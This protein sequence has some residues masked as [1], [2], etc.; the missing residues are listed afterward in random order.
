M[1]TLAVAAMVATSVVLQSSLVDKLAIWGI[2]PDLPL[3]L[4]I[5]LALLYGWRRGALVGLSAGL[6][7]DLLLGRYLG[8]DALALGLTG[9]LVGLAEPR[10][11]KENVLAVLFG[12]LSGTVFAYSVEFVILT[13]LGRP[14]DFLFAWKD[15]IAP[16]AIWNALLGPL[17]Y[18]QIYRVV[19][20]WQ[21]H[22]G[23][24][25]R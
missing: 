5:D 8:L 7:Q 21:Y 9:A 13:I 1:S 11:W 25:V 4:T 20:R 16:A 14:M 10:V 17:L 2:K 24:N 15:A 3:L 19:A 18:W 23:K 22:T 12:C 6:W